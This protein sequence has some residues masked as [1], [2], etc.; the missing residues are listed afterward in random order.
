MRRLA[1]AAFAILCLFVT[2]ATVTAQQPAPKAPPQPVP[3]GPAYALIFGPVWGP[4]NRP[5]YGA[6]VQ[7]R[8]ADGTKVKGGEGLSSDHQ[9]EFALRVPAGGADYVVRAAA[10]Q[11]KRKLTAEVKV[12]IDFD[13]RVD[14]G[15]HL[16][17]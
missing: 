11:D 3:K 14:V 7:V 16:T 2:I 13:E 12:H 10:K 4:D 9:G 8:R 5:V 17:E 15:L 1:G 6:R